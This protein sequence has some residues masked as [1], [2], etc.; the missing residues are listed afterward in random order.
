MQLF[1][2]LLSGKANSEDPDQTD[3]SKK[4]RQKSMQNYLACKVLKHSMLGKNFSILMFFSYFRLKT[5]FDIGDNMHE[6]SKPVLGGKIR[7]IIQNVISWSAEIITQ[8]AKHYY[9]RLLLGE[10]RYV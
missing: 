8:H 1:L 2:K 6:I 3:P 4:K 9:R 10:I 5:G 7:K